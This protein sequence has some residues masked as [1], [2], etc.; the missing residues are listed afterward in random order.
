MLRQSEKTDT[1]EN[2]DVK[3][4]LHLWELDYRMY[5]LL[6]CESHHPLTAVI[7]R[8]SFVHH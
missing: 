6:K 1:R 7:L 3:R 8:T 4:Q 2:G 5:F